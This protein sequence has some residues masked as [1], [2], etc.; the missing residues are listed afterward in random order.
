MDSK[1]QNINGE[2]QASIVITEESLDFN[3][4]QELATTERGEEEYRNLTWKNQND[5]GSQCQSSIVNW[6]DHG[7]IPQT[8]EE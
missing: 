6:H 1:K 2:N 4:S 3:Q 7:D 8:S 5:P